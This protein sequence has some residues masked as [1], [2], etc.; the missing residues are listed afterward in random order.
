MNNTQILKCEK[1]NYF[2]FVKAIERELMDKL[3][4]DFDWVEKDGVFFVEDNKLPV[5]NIELIVNSP[6]DVTLY[7]E[8]ERTI[9]YEYEAQLLHELLSNRWKFLNFAIEN[10][11]GDNYSDLTASY[12]M[13][14]PF[15]EK[16]IDYAAAHVY[17]MIYEFASEVRE[18]E[19]YLEEWFEEEYVEEKEIKTTLELFEH[20]LEEYDEG[21][22]LSEEEKKY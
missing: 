12:N 3:N 9:P 15:D 8:F 1:N 11:G 13:V 2:E 19:E 16:K 14:F 6:V 5:Q 17:S 7:V 20:V 4:Y 18:C 10:Y 21:E 22:N